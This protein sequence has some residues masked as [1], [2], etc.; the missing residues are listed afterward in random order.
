M[1]VSVGTPPPVFDPVVSA[2]SSRRSVL[3]RL[4]S[5]GNGRAGLIIVVA[6]VLLGLV[7]LIGIQ[8]HGPNDQDVYHA[9]KGQ[10][11]RASCRE[12]V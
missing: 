5:R 3:A 9:L 8:P 6:M 7:S 2:Q 12:R 10:I 1:S 4:W 11:G